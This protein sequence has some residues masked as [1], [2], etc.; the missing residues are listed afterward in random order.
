MIAARLVTVTQVGQVLMAEWEVVTRFTKYYHDRHDYVFF[1]DLYIYIY[2]IERSFWNFGFGNPLIVLSLMGCCRNL[3]N[4][5][6]NS[7]EDRGLACDVSAGNRL[8]QS[9][10]CDSEVPG[11]WG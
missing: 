10:S 11:S 6:E 2:K 7:A 4:N 8:C 5:A 9:H 1:F 3:E